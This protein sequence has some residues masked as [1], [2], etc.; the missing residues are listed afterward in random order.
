MKNFLTNAF[1]AYI[2]KKDIRNFKKNF[3][4]Y[5]LFRL[6]RK[7]LSSKVIVNIYNFKLYASNKK[8][9]TSYSILRKCDFEDKSELNFIK[10]ISD[11]NSKRCLFFWY[12]KH[13]NK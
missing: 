11:D 6:V 10:K 2:E 5:F 8:N 4:Y 13:G 12:Y 3:I 9:T 1:Q 7:F